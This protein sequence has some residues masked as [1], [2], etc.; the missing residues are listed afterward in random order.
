MSSRTQA[1][2]LLLFA[3]TLL[4]LGTSD[5]L[6]RFV[7]DSAR[8]WVLVAGVLIALLGAWSLVASA[9]HDEDDHEQGAGDEHGP[10]PGLDAHGHSSASRS[11]WLVLLPVVAV[12]VIGPP[13]LGE[14][15]VSRRAP[16][17]AQ[18]AGVALAP[19]PKGDPVSLGVFDYA[20]HAV[21]DGGAS[22]RGRTVSI[23][24]FVARREKGGF[25][26]ARLVIT[27]CAADATPVAVRITAP[28]AGGLPVNT[29]V[30]VTGRYAP[31]AAD[32]PDVPGLAAVRVERVPTP[33]EPYD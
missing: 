4:R 27:C 18:P 13:A 20:L 25:L 22:V 6:L 5:V 7:K 14:Y 31:P 8:P 2:V 21:T 16:V 30:R 29:W 15:T 3:A 33:S 24:G 19:L 32:D 28:D 9:R 11:A 12:L 26:L 10:G 1:F 23:T 17:A